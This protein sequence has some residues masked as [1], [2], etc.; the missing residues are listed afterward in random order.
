MKRSDVIS[1][2]DAA[3]RF[4][5]D[6]HL[7]RLSFNW[8]RTVAR[9]RR[10][11]EPRVVYE[12]AKSNWSAYS[13][14]VPGCV[15]TG[16]TRE[17]VVAIFKEALEFHLEGLREDGI[18]P[19]FEVDSPIES[20]NSLALL[21][22]VRLHNVQAAKPIQVLKAK[23]YDGTPSEVLVIKRTELDRLRNFLLKAD[24]KKPSASFKRTEFKILT[25]IS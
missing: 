13:P 16:K 20:G 12:K 14:D 6:P 1:F 5:H 3:L 9:K 10:A 7:R 25:K 8:T 4:S 11:E 15:A 23:G 17:Q 2:S 18:E 24:S 22:A 21:K 19:S